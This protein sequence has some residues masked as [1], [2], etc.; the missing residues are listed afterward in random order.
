M[1]NK[2]DGDLIEGGA[3][4][5]ICEKVVKHLSTLKRHLKT[6]HEELDEAT[7]TAKVEMVRA[8]KLGQKGERFKERRPCEVK[9]CR[10][11]FSFVKNY[12]DHMREAHGENSPDLTIAI[13]KSDR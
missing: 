6:V 5:D 1:K 12:L 9:N 3:K 2:H 7:I 13:R 8:E 4:C 11:S 10:G